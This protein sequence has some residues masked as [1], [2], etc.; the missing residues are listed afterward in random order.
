MGEKG[1]VEGWS[2]EM[3]E[4]GR[5]ITIRITIKIEGQP[6]LPQPSGEAGSVKSVV[7]SLSPIPHS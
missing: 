7:S 6:V 4:L 2:D 1:V 5:K 3:G